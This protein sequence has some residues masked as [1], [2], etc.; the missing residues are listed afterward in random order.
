M[1]FLVVLG[2]EFFLLCLFDGLPVN[3]RHSL[4]SERPS[5]TNSGR[6]LEDSFVKLTG[7]DHWKF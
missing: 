5:A 4:V 6:K 7:V 2:C 3:K 1:R